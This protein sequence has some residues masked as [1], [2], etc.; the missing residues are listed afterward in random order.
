M[1]HTPLFRINYIIKGLHGARDK[2]LLSNKMNVIKL[3]ETH[4]IWKWTA[5]Y[6]MFASVLALGYVSYKFKRSFPDVSD[7]E[8]NE[9]NYF[10]VTI[11]CYAWYVW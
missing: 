9:T 10:H 11:Y 8:L 1:F 6:I 4:R 3:H 5:R 7:M 2:H